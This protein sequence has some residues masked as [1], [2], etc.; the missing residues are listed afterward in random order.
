MHPL[1]KYQKD[2][3]DS[4]FDYSNLNTR[5]S[6]YAGVSENYPEAKV[7]KSMVADYLREKKKPRFIEHIAEDPIQLHKREH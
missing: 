2:M 6:L 7:S 1:T 3:L 4:L 5:E